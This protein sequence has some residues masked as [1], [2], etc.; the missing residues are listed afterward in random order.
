MLASLLKWA[1]EERLLGGQR[2]RWEDRFRVKFRNYT[3]RSE[4]HRGVPD[5]AASEI[6]HLSEPINQI[7]GLQA[8]RLLSGRW[9]RLP[10]Q[11]PPSCMAWLK[12]SGTSTAGLPSG[13]SGD[14]TVWLGPVDGRSGCCPLRQRHFCLYHLVMPIG[15]KIRGGTGAP[16]PGPGAGGSKPDR[17]G[18]PASP[19]GFRLDALGVPACPQLAHQVEHAPRRGYL[20]PGDQLPRA[21]D[22]VASLAINP[23]TAL[24]ANRELETKSLTPG[25]PGQSTF[26]KATPSQVALPELTALR[27]SLPGWPAADG[28]G[29]DEDGIVALLTS[30]L[31]DF[32]ERRGGQADRGAAGGETEGAA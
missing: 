9:S 23:D 30:A 8:A 5:D 20:K 27:R 7:W 26:I 12:G 22:L 17:Q 14:G 13:E 19:A 21:R 15:K 28:A 3:A 1:R 31:R 24:K 29:P 16:P 32:H 6:F 25:R 18:G 4:Y 10:G 11:I 2:D